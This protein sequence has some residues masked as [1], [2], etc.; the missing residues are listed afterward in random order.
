MG[1]EAVARRALRLGRAGTCR[2]R[3]AVG[4]ELRS[5]GR[6]ARTRGGGGQRRNCEGSSVFDQRI[7]RAD[8]TGAVVYRRRYG[9]AAPGGGS[10]SS[11]GCYFWTDRSSS[12]RA[13]RD[14]QPGVA[15]S[16]EPHNARA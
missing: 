9:A 2:V 12:E 13:V 1:R 10:A 3:S 16:G 11:G 14:E 7:D 6:G 15:E 4:G 8:A 5:G